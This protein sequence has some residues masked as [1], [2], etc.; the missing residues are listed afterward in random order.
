MILLVLGL[1]LFLGIHS[2]S[3]VAPAWRDRMAARLGD[4]TWKGLYSLVSFAGLGLLLWGYGEARL[5]PTMVYVPPPWMHYVTV[6]LMAPVF[7]L[8]MA[9]YLPGRIKTGARHPFLVA[10]KL[11]AAAHLLS[12]GTVHSVV[13]FGSFLAWAVVDRISLKRRTERPVAGAPPSAANDWIAVGVGLGLYALAIGWTHQKFIG[14]S[15]L[16]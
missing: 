15:P 13:L 6:V 12:N 4:G 1:V 8:L 3:I 7:P 5:H 14:T 10:T 16:G 9:A 11:W 2:V